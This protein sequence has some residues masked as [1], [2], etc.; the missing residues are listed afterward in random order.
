LGLSGG[1]GRAL[2]CGEEDCGDGAESVSVT[3]PGPGLLVAAV[4]TADPARCP[5]DSAGDLGMCR[6]VPA[7]VDMDRFSIGAMVRRWKAVRVRKRKNKERRRHVLL[8]YLILIESFC[9]LGGKTVGRG[10]D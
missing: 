6:M 8:S 9:Q 10:C 4:V 3:L 2:E 7:L 5:V 1:E